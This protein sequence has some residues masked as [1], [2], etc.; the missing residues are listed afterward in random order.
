[1]YG[2][3]RHNCDFTV[4]AWLTLQGSKSEKVRINSVCLAQNISPSSPDKIDFFL[5]CEEKNRDIVD[6]ADFPLGMHA[7]MLRS[8][9]RRLYHQRST[10]GFQP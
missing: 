7:I 1:V 9:R 10:N 3:P 4:V 6:I 5:C 2:F 8:S